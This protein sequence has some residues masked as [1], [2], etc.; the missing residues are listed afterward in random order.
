MENPDLKNVLNDFVPM[1]NRI[2]L[3]QLLAGPIKSLKLVLVCNYYDLKRGKSEEID[4][5]K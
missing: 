4:Y 3:N 2:Y 5:W 1:M